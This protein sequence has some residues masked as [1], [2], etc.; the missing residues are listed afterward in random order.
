MNCIHEEANHQ[1]SCLYLFADDLQK[2]Q[3]C[4]LQEK[5]ETI[6]K[7]NQDSQALVNKGLQ[8]VFKINPL[9]TQVMILG[10]NRNLE[11]LKQIDVPN[12]GVHNQVVQMSSTVENLGVLLSSHLSWNEHLNK[13][14]KSIKKTYLSRGLIAK[15]CKSNI[16]NNWSAN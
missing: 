8:L 14:T 9:K 4:T 2:L 12:V 3:I 13:I 11:K 16:K 10:S 5:C 6:R 7:I 15:T 1:R